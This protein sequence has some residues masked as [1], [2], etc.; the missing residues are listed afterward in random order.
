[1]SYTVSLAGAPSP[2][3]VPEVKYPDT[4]P[5][6]WTRGD[7]CHDE[8]SEFLHE[9]REYMLIPI[10]RDILVKK[11]LEFRI[12]EPL[13]TVKLPTLACEELERRALAAEACLEL[14]ERALNLAHNRDVARLKVLEAFEMKR[15]A[16]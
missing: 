9:I 15:C 14:A 8:L 12:P 11:E 16:K 13:Q 2:P 5:S 1:M 10:P 4:S 6:G 3:K 7:W